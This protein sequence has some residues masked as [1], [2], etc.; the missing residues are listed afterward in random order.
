MSANQYNASLSDAIAFKLENPEEKATTAAQIFGV[1]DVPVRT[2]LRR[3]QERS[4][5]IK[6]RG[7]NKI[8]LEVQ[9]KAIY[10]DVEDL[11][12]SGYSATRAIVY[13]KVG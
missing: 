7:H 1:N 10:K 9:V 8:P 3:N 11:Y 12:L 5:A 2:N 6:H 4:K 13:A